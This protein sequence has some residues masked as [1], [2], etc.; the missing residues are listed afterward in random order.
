MSNPR[1]R[2]IPIRVA[3]LGE[4]GVWALIVSAFLVLYAPHATDA[5]TFVAHLQLVGSVLLLLAGVRLAIARCTPSDLVARWTAAVLCALAL[6]SVVGYYALVLTGLHLWGRVASWDMVVAYLQR[7]RD[8]EALTGMPFWTV[9]TASLV[10]FAALVSAWARIAGTWDGLARI[11]RRVP[12]RWV[13][14]GTWMVP[15]VLLA[16]AWKEPRTDVREPISLTRFP[17]EVRL[18]VHA[19]RARLAADLEAKEEYVPA[20]APQR[21]NVI[22]IVVDALRADHMSVYGYQRPT[23]PFLASQVIARKANVA[24]PLTAVCPESFC[25]LVGMARSSFSHEVT[26]LG[27]S[28]GEVLERHGYEIHM[29]LSGDHTHYY[30]LKQAYGRTTSYVDGN[31]AHP[32]AANDDEFVLQ[33]VSALPRWDGQPKMIQF[34]LMSSHVL[35]VRRP[36]SELWRPAAN[37]WHLRTPSHSGKLPEAVNFY[38]N[39]VRQTDAIV[40]ELLQALERK[41][42]LGDALVVITADHGEALGEHGSMGHAKDVLQGPLRIPLVLMRYGYDSQETVAHARWGS[43]VDIAPTILRELRMP[44]PANWRGSA[45]QNPQ[46]S[47]PFSFFAHGASVGLIDA[48]QPGRVLKF[49]LDLRRQTSRTF[50]LSSDPDEQVDISDSIPTPLRAEWLQ[51]LRPSEEWAR[52]CCAARTEPQSAAPQH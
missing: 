48:R 43:Q 41:G 40:Q 17:Q 42:Y 21:R 33:K 2:S 3:L 15:G 28:L 4:A 25:G 7:P 19:D 52:R 32:L 24:P 6:V 1:D 11:A 26:H 45:L 37:Y 12:W 51:V 31:S 10:A 35:G 27:L 44:A 5:S 23:T 47:R 30:G 50:D 20:S 22:L 9:V 16:V 36:G 29:V 13:I 46:F 8:L 39:G 38:D 14:L 49:W 34:H 18:G